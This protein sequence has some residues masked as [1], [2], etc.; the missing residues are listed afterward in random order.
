MCLPDYQGVGIGNALSEFVASL[1]VATGK[2][3]YSV[4]GNPAM[5]RHRAKSPLWNMLRKPS[6]VSPF[7]SR[8]FN[9]QGLRKTTASNRFT[10]GFNYVGPARR[11]D[12]WRFGLM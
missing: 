12:A 3:Y 6:R 7:N 1:F 9:V 4:T 8:H 5:I 11:R 2:R 10:A